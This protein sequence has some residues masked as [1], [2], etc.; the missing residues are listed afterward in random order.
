MTENA[1]IFNSER[2][3]F[4]KEE[5]KSESQTGFFWC[6]SQNLQNVD[7][8]AIQYLNALP[9]EQLNIMCIFLTLTENSCTRTITSI[10]KAVLSGERPD[11]TD[12]REKRISEMFSVGKFQQQC[13]I[14]KD[15]EIGWSLQLLILPKPETSRA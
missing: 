2:Q 15:K 8:M 9:R 13:N 11:Q 6:A 12:G 1:T 7:Y 14:L 5:H 3:V 10:G 4:N